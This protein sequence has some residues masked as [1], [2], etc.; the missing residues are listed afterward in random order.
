MEFCNSMS[1]QHDK[2]CGEGFY[3]HRF[4]RFYFLTCRMGGE[5]NWNTVVGLLYRM[6]VFIWES[7]ILKSRKRHSRDYM[8]P[9]ANSMLEGNKYLHVGTCRL[10]NTLVFF[11]L[12]MRACNCVRVCVMASFFLTEFLCCRHL[13]SA[14]SPL[15]QNTCTG[16]V[17]IIS[18]QQPL[19]G[20]KQRYMRDSCPVADLRE[21]QWELCSDQTVIFTSHELNLQ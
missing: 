15:N 12:H 9:C 14:L 19:I 16:C 6:E 5:V 20:F 4:C 10:H 11:F 13:L 18:G 17:R 3:C 1:W 7:R 2:T 8:S 21:A